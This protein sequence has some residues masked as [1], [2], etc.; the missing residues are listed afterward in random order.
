VEGLEAVTDCLT[1]RER[2][3]LSMHLLYDSYALS[4]TPVS[5]SR[6]KAHNRHL[7]WGSP[8]TPWTLLLLL[9]TLLLRGTGSPPMKSSK[10]GRPWR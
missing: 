1:S 4:S 8:V 6:Q 5:I 2:C 7:Y 3:P 9:L 10:A